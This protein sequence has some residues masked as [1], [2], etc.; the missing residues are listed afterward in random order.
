LAAAICLKVIPAYLLVYSAWKR[1]VRG[2]LGCA[3]GLLIGLV[4]LPVA[5]LG[6]ER[7]LSEYEA[8]GR[9]RF[10]PLFRVSD[11][12]SRH[13]ELL[14]VNA[15]DSVGIKNAMHNWMYR[16]RDRR[17]EQH[18][19]AVVWAY[20]GLGVL[21]TLLVLWP[22]RARDRH[23]GWS[24]VLRYGALIQLMTLFSPICHM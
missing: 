22:H 2:L 4:A 9:V 3:A 23:E 24:F 16:D 19:P 1:D 12:R 20:R 6:P 21:M 13:D 11:D 8:Y 5:V 18:H 15:T 7:A 14:G 10:G 17:P